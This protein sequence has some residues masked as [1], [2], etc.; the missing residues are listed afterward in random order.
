MAPA[1]Q[2]ERRSRGHQ[3][4]AEQHHR[5]GRPAAVPG[6]HGEEQAQGQWQDPRYLPAEGLLEE[7]ERTRGARDRV[8]GSRAGAAAEPAE[9]VAAD[10]TG[11]DAETTPAGLGLE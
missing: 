4:A 11:L 8:A 5:G 9:A 7:P 1:H 3:P 2:A 6:D 10:D